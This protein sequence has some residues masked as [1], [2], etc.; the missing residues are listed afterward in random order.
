V[1]PDQV[2]RA[3]RANA[4]R[5]GQFVRRVAAKRDVIEQPLGIDAAALPNFGWTDARPFAGTY[6]N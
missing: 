1:P 5:A 6:G 2:G 4:A 3:L